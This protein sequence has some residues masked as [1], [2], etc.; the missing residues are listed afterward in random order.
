M[1]FDVER[2]S[3]KESFG[4]V[5]TYDKLFVNVESAMNLF[6]G[7]FTAP[8]YGVY[9][10]EARARLGIDLRANGFNV[11]WKGQSPSQNLDNNTEDKDIDSYARVTLAA[12]HTVNLYNTLDVDPMRVRF[13]GFREE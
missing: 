11:Y 10:F 6:T 9:Y 12:G 2:I 13:K 1:L 8:S 4:K 3:V 7:T 5:V